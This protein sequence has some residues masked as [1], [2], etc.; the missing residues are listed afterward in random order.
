MDLELAGKIALVTGAAGNSIGREIARQLAA[1]GAQ[2][3]ILAR[4]GELLA[5]L[6]DEIESAGGKRPLAIV[7]DITDGGMFSRTRDQV[8]REFGRLDIMVNAAGG[9]LRF[10]SDPDEDVQDQAW[11][12]GFA[13]TFTPA[14]KLASAFLP[15]MQKRKWGRIIYVTGTLEVSKYGPTQATKIAV[16]TWAKGLACEVGK[17][18]ITVNCVAPSFSHTEQGKRRFPTPESEAKVMAHSRNPIGYF[19]EPYDI[20]YMATFLC[21]PKA[22]YITGKV[23]YV[24]GG[25]HRAL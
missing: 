25:T 7:G 13:T 6:Q 24:D 21:S 20:A 22:R 10:P 12:H 16:A 5:K 17:Y 19:S 8:L 4:R 1:E 11:D 15:V 18:G 2:T 23:I 9:G 14:R 3:V